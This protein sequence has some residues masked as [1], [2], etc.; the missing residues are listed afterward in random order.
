MPWLSG[1]VFYMALNLPVKG[2]NRK[3]TTA[4]WIKSLRLNWTNLISVWGTLAQVHVSKNDCVQPRLSS[5]LDKTQFK[6]ITEHAVY[7][8]SFIRTKGCYS[9][10]MYKYGW[11]Q[12]LGFFMMINLKEE[13]KHN[14][15]KE[16]SGYFRHGFQSF[17]TF[18]LNLYLQDFLI[19]FER[20]T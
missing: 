11:K 9:D 15:L 17:R 14:K 7:N 8:H 18:S 3:V 16:I 10:L 1:C 6:N 12:A 19:F 5:W 2:K 13:C 20:K 4:S